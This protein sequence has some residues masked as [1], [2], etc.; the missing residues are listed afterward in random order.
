M[1]REQARAH[2]SRREVAGLIG[3]SAGAERRRHPAAACIRARDGHARRAPP[4][5]IVMSIVFVN[6]AEPKHGP[7]WK[8]KPCVENVSPTRLT[9]SGIGSTNG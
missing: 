8:L 1:E 2:G 5:W 6:D 4:H 9:F 7:A 3:P